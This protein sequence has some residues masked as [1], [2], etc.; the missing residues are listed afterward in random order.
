[1]NAAEMTS[2]RCL[3]RALHALLACGGRLRGCGLVLLLLCSGLACGAPRGLEQL[4]H[5]RWTTSDDGPSQVGALAQSADGYLWLG[6]ND[7]LYRFDGFRFVRYQTPEGGSLGIV[8]ALLATDDGLW[9]GLRA[10]GARFIGRQGTR[11][12]APGSELPSGVLYGFARDQDGAIWAAANDGLA[13]F[14]GKRWETIGTNWQFPGGARAVLVDREGRVWAAS[15]EHL[16]YLPVGARAFVDSGLAP[17]WV[18]QMAQAADG[19]IWLAERYGGALQRLTLD[20]GR[21]VSSTA[22]VTLAANGLLFDTQG[23]L[24]ISTLG[25][26]LQHAAE[27]ALLFDP[28]RSGAALERYATRDGLSSDYLWPLLQD[29]DGNLWV[30]SSAGLDRFREHAVHVAPLPREALNF[31]LAPGADGSLWA[32]SS[33]RPVV[34]LAQGQLSQLEM[35]APVTSALRDA[36]GG[37]WMAGPNG[38]WRSRGERLEKVAALPTHQ[39][40][41]SPVRAM[42]RDDAGDLWVSINR[43]G[44]FRLHDGVWREFP[45]PTLS[46]SQKMPVS[47][48]R[49]SDGTLWFG[50]RDNL[51]LTHGRA[52]ERQWGEQDGLRVGHVTALQL[53]SRR[54]WVAGEHGLAWFDGARFHSLQLPDSGLFDNIYAVLAVPTQA[55]EDLWLHARGGIF[56]LAAADIE[57]AIADPAQRLRYRAYDLRGGLANDPYQVLPLPT[58]V[59]GDDGRLWFSTS[60]GVVWIDP[61]Q[62]KDKDAP[63]RV[64]IESLDVDGVRLSGN[65][66]LQLPARSRRLMIDYTALSLSMP[67]GLH[68][69]Y[70]LDGY[71]RDWHYAG[72]GRQAIYTGL[73]PGDYRFRVHAA[74]ADGVPAEQEAQ[75]SFSIAPVFYQR[76]LFLIVFG[77][78]LL[79]LFWAFYRSRLRRA[80]DTLRARLE[81]RHSER[82]RIAR[83][84]HDTLLQGVQG[85]MLHFQAAAESLAEDQPVRQRMERAL[86]RADQVLAEGR[87]RVR[88]LRRR[89][90]AVADLATA[91]EAL[92]EELEHDPAIAFTVSVR[93]RPHDLRPLVRDEAYCIGRE[94]IANAFGHARAAQ[95]SVRIRYTP[96]RFVLSIADDGCGIAAEYL[97]P[98]G[99]PDHWGLSGMHERAQKLGGELNI[100][101]APAQGSEIRLSLPA[102]LAYRRTPRRWRRWL[103]YLTHPR[104]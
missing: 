15:E 71:D 32:G 36:E 79:G 59:R 73:G 67:E 1:M 103:H 104:S 69:R 12:Y 2:P 74:N 91:F 52:G 27:P 89:S 39:A 100:R 17:G 43:L 88:N 101:S 60:N 54:P 20:A 78:A 40:P 38:I 85:L 84:L 51:I 82:E 29:H 49:A 92:E 8:S 44:L 5:R 26:G 75:L 11:Q 14:D 90:L 95:V 68:F 6:T 16:Y 72:S 13:R 62:H 99:R 56:Q 55:G 42:V 10:G 3:A 48:A 30:G 4:E 25:N 19:S 86:D 76:P 50:Y 33:N 21:V 24:W 58:A 81:E 34:R 66:P 28:A 98:G 70:R 65:R 96:Q 37:I 61:A 18:S 64:L 93:G 102:T 22:T 41:D 46:P 87:E 23:G 63:P 9:V 94:A 31:A 77:A 7:S 83:E 47:A 80:A 53:R 35:P 45:A 57:K 97:G